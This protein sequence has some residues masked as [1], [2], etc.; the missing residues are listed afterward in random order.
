MP[1]HCMLDL[2]TLGRSHDAVVLQIGQCIFDE[3]NLLFHGAW[4]VK[5]EDALKH[6]TITA[7]TVLWWLKQPDEARKSVFE[8]PNAMELRNALS[9]FTNL[10]KQSEIDHFWAHA[11]FDFPIIANAFKAVGLEN[12]I[13]FRKCR[14]IRTLDMLAHAAT[15]EGW[16]KR[17]GI[18]HNAMDDAT[19]Q[20]KC[21]QLMLKKVDWV[22]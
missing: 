17:E 19:H 12:P 6:G 7:D 9:Y 1:I 18:Y 15:I 14:D 21:V 8:Q 13:D 16:P 3:D 4:T 11:S 2:E 10:V 5:L 20:A 22:A